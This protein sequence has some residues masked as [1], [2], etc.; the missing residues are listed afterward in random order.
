MT[1]DHGHGDYQR[2]NMDI[3]D[4]VKGWQGFTSFVK[5]SMG[6]ILLIMIFL[7]IFRTHG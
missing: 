6:G 7:A 3:K 2:G 4:H 1:A 5:W